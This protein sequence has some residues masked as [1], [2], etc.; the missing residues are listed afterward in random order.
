M[1][2]TQG[3]GWDEDKSNMRRK[4]NYEKDTREGKII[5]TRTQD[6]E[7]QYGKDTREG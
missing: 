7:R 6:T 1:T 5:M 3:Q 4:D 2:R